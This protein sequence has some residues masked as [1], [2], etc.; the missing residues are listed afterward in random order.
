MHPLV[1]VLVLKFIMLTH[2]PLSQLPNA[3]LYMGS[4]VDDY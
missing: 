3:K 1:F 4:S 2:L